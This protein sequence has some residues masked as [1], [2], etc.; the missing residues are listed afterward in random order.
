[1]G[2]ARAYGRGDQRIRP[3]AAPGARVEGCR[4]RRE[5]SLTREM[6][7]Q[8]ARQSPSAPTNCGTER[9]GFRFQTRPQIFVTEP[10]ASAVFSLRIL[11]LL[12]IVFVAACAEREGQEASQ[13]EPRAAASGAPGVLDACAI[14]PKGDVEQVLTSAVG[15]AVVVDSSKSGE[16]SCVHAFTGDGRVIVAAADGRPARPPAASFSTPAPGSKPTAPQS[17]RR[18][19]GESGSVSVYV[20]VRYVRDLGAAADTL[21]QRALRENPSRAPRSR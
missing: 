21:V 10:T 6:N 19:S 7:R 17:V 20:E 16:G 8:D 14:L 4:D 12:P 5:Q 3:E 2:S 9:I 13:A 15:A 11:C 1:M 18:V